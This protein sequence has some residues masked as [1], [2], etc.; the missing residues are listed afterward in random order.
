M[1]HRDQ[2]MVPYHR[3]YRDHEVRAVF[4]QWQIHR[5]W[6]SWRNHWVD[7]MNITRRYQAG[8]TLYEMQPGSVTTSQ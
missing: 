5:V 7:W 1:L 6:P 4:A 2:E 8:L 3:T